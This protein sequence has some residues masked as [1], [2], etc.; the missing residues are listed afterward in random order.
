MR[1]LCLILWLCP[2]AV[3]LPTSASAC[4]CN[5]AEEIP[6][7]IERSDAV[8]RGRVLSVSSA[9]MFDFKWPSHAWIV[10]FEVLTSW[11]GLTETETVVL[12]AKDSTACGISFDKDVEYLVFASSRGSG[13]HLWTSTCDRTDE[14]RPK[15][16][17]LQ[18]LETHLPP[19]TLKPKSPPT[20]SCATTGASPAWAMLLLVGLLY[21]R[22]RRR[23]RAS[24]PSPGSAPR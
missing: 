2:L 14:I 20:S 6:A 9:G 15:S 1:A 19:L 11:K 10:R 16:E 7:L 22:R 3:L 8:F 18:H 5:P 24:S 4:S 21:P 17:T 13:G 23:F 12:T